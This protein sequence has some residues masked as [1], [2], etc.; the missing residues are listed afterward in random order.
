MGAKADYKVLWFV[1]RQHGVGATDR[2]K[3]NYGKT[4]PFIG[5]PDIVTVS[6]L[7]IHYRHHVRLLSGCLS[8]QLSTIISILFLLV[9]ALSKWTEVMVMV[10]DSVVVRWKLQQMMK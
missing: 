9:V 8:L 4:W 3:T 2:Q 5:G 10:S 7:P 1:C 6:R